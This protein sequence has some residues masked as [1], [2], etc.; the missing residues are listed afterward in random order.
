MNLANKIMS[1]TA[2]AL[3]LACGAVE[4]AGVDPACAGKHIFSDKPKL[5]ADGSYIFEQDG[6]GNIATT[7][8]GRQQ[9]S[10]IDAVP[11]GD[12]KWCLATIEVNGQVNGNSF[13]SILTVGAF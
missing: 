12:G 13:N 6:Y 5:Q 4:A 1:L 2:C 11:K 10:V 9:Y 8:I 7:L 3:V